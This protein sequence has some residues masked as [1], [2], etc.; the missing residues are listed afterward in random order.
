MESYNFEIA[1]C[2]TD[3]QE[4]LAKL[5]VERIDLLITDVSMP[6]ID[7][8]TLMKKAKNL[9]PDL[10]VIVV[11][12][13]DNFDYVKTALRNGAENYLLKPLNQDELIETLQKTVENIENDSLSKLYQH[14]YDGI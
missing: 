7:G 2:F 9:Y 12:A 13:Y 1:G 3:P 6:V 4:A 10:K 11:S 5:R 8:L 14:K